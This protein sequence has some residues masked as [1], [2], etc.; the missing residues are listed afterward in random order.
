MAGPEKA[1]TSIR[2]ALQRGKH[3]IAASL[4]GTSLFWR[5]LPETIGTRFAALVETLFDGVSGVLLGTAVTISLADLRLFGVGIDVLLY[6]YLISVFLPGY[7]PDSEHTD[8]L[9]NSEKLVTI[10]CVYVLALGY[11]ISTMVPELLA[12]SPIEIVVRATGVPL[13]PPSTGDLPG[14]IVGWAILGWSMLSVYIY[15]TWWRTASVEARVQFLLDIVPAQY[16]TAV[17]L[18][19]HRRQ[20]DAVN[21]I[22]D[23]FAIIAIAGV[24]MFT[25]LLFAFLT[26]VAVVLFPLPEILILI[27]AIASR[28]SKF[29]SPTWITVVAEDGM[30]IEDQIFSVARY[31]RAGPKGLATTSLISSAVAI[32]MI[33]VSLSLLSMVYSIRLLPSNT[34]G[35]TL[36][37]VQYPVRLAVLGLITSCLVVSGLYS[38]WYWIRELKRFPHFLDY[39]EARYRPDETTEPFAGLDQPPT[40]PPGTLVIPSL[41]FIPI[42]LVNLFQSRLP[43]LWALMLIWLLAIGLFRLV[44]WSISWTLRA[45]PQE[46]QTDSWAIPVAATTQ[47]SW[48]I[49]L[50]WISE[51]AGPWGAPSAFVLLTALILSLGVYSS[52]E[53]DLILQQQ[54]GRYASDLLNTILSVSTLSIGGIWIIFTESMLGWM[55]FGGGILITAVSV[56]NIL[57]K[58]YTSAVDAEELE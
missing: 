5:E 47:Y 37:F 29:R 40:R 54:V 28:V 33:Q 46:P 56:G 3:A 55:L 2:Q 24:L 8:A 53:I 31:V 27:T 25:S 43:P 30:A 10:L 57:L 41:L 6:F 19:A 39:W 48:L 26:G 42:L 16:G 9:V 50:F 35:V 45:S 11:L 12:T 17:H 36:L 49:G 14:L 38:I 1:A 32:S 15:A 51:Q 58:R 20:S 7:L 21:R 22:L 44:L 18:K 23:C 34:G 4:A 52:P 13:Q